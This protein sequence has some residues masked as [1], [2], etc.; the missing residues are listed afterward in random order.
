MYR[1]PTL[2][3]LGTM[4]PFPPPTPRV[5]PPRPQ[6]CLLHLTWSSSPDPLPEPLGELGAWRPPRRGTHAGSRHPLT[7]ASAAPTGRPPPGLLPGVAEKG[8]LGGVSPWQPGPVTH[9]HVF[10]P[11]PRLLPAHT[12]PL[13][14]PFMGH[15]ARTPPP[16]VPGAAPSP[17]SAGTCP[18]PSPPSLGLLSPIRAGTSTSTVQA[19]SCSHLGEPV[20]PG[21]PPSSCWAPYDPGP[22]REG[23]GVQ[24]GHS[25]SPKRSEDISLYRLG[26][27]GSVWLEGLLLQ[28]ICQ[29]PPRRREQGTPGLKLPDTTGATSSL[30][31]K[32]TGSFLQN[33]GGIAEPSFHIHPPPM[34]RKI[35]LTS[36]SDRSTR[37]RSTEEGTR[38][39][40]LW[41]PPQRHPRASQLSR[42]ALPQQRGTQASD[43]AG[44]GDEGA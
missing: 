35:W 11:P 12:Q 40:V 10:P 38:S 28:S 21:C 25:P 26:G 9:T 19:P 20:A 6:P 24:E 44:G 16:P 13:A 22:G 3:Q 8:C 27:G 29:R 41:A 39:P 43:P 31:G 5:P 33:L 34:K 14:C 4:S 32:G 7:L 37:R 30:P 17:P 2:L 18:A 36:V 42:R 15:W 1:T 23:N